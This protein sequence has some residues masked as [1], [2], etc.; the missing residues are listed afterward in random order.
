MYWGEVNTHLQPDLHRQKQPERRR[1]SPPGITLLSVWPVHTTSSPPT[2]H[3]HFSSTASL[4]SSSFSSPPPP[5]PHLLPPLPALLPASSPPPPASPSLPVV[6][7]GEFSDWRAFAGGRESLSA[8]R[9]GGRRPTGRRPT[10]GGCERGGP[11]A[12]RG[13]RSARSRGAPERRRDHG[14][15]RTESD[16]PERER[17]RK[18]EGNTDIITSYIYVLTIGLNY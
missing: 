9:K 1:L 12:G 7:R 4:P 10:P 18:K 15:S 11:G 17:E 8:P 5:P 16:T 6:W 2:P 3:T 13:Q 14:G